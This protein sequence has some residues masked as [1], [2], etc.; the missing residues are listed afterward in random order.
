MRSLT[1]LRRLVRVRSAVEIVKRFV[2][3]TGVRNPGGETVTVNVKL[4]F[5]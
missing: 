2:H 1:W 5:D 3:L 4:F